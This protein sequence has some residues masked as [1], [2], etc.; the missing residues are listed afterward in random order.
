MTFASPY[1]VAVNAPGVWVHELLSAEPFF[2]IADVVEEIAAVS[3]DTG[4]PLT[5]YARSTNGITSS[6]LLV[7]DPSRTHGT[8]GIADCE[9]A[10][11]ALAARG[12]W[13]S[14]GQD[15]RSCML[16]ALGLREGYDPA[17]RVHSPDEVINRVLSKGQVWCGW[18]AELISARPQP[19]GPAQVYH[20]PGVLAFTDFDQMPTLAAIA[21]DLRQDRFVIHN[22]LTGWTTAFRRPAGPHGT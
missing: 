9:R 17:A 18:P 5:A 11:A 16:L 12:T 14:R 22:W 13:L 8:P 4:V 21:H 20:E 19:D 15:A 7:R 3:Q 6:L 2:P 10:A 1:V